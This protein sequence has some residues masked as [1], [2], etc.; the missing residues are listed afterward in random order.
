MNVHHDI[1]VTLSD[2]HLADGGRCE[3]F[4]RDEEFAAL[5]AHV[6]AEHPTAHVRLQLLGDIFDPLAVPIDG[7]Y[8]PLPYEGVCVRQMERIIAAHPVFFDA[9]VAFH[10]DPRTEIVF[11][12]GNHDFFVEWDGVQAQ[13]LRRISGG[14]SHRIRFAYEELHHGVYYHHGNFEPNNA[15]E[16]TDRYILPSRHTKAREALLN[17]PYGSYLTAQTMP[18]LRELHPYVGRL[19][20]H[21]YLY[22][23]AATRN[24][25][26]GLYAL[27]MYVENFVHNR[28][29]AFWDVRRKTS[30]VMTLRI[31]WWTVAGSKQEEIAERIIEKQPKIRAVV[32]GHD[33]DARDREIRGG[34][35]LNTGTWSLQYDIVW[36]DTPN[37]PWGMALLTRFANWISHLWHRP[38]FVKVERLPV[39]LARHGDA[40][41]EIA[42]YHWNPQER[43]LDRVLTEGQ[44]DRR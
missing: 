12:I 30:L 36:H 5:L 19:A 24:W 15:I 29:F 25:K 9:L 16:M 7:V 14:H 26:L 28:F 43:R 31:L 22:K 35:F 20:Y 34:R 8:D 42:L 3:D 4:H 41:D 13:L 44:N 23:E 39:V 32:C 1:V 40:V 21:G 2:L 11:F 37:P 10:A 38:E 17:Y 6:R 18:K 33:H 27:W